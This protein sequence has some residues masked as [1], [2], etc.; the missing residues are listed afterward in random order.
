MLS[1]VQPDFLSLPP[2]TSFHPDNWPEEVGRHTSSFLLGLFEGEN[3]SSSINAEILSTVSC[4]SVGGITFSMRN[5]KPSRSLKN[6][7]HLDT[8]SF[9]GCFLYI[10]PL[11]P[12]RNFAWQSWE[13]EPGGA[14]KGHCI[15]A[16]ISLSLLWIWAG[17]SGL[18]A[19]ICVLRWTATADE[20]ALVGRRA[21]LGE[22]LE[23]ALTLHL[24]P[25]TWE[26]AWD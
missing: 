17:T 1:L 6:G 3:L 24:E 14:G 5:F 8:Q 18:G 13:T 23:N 12:T 2:S 9:R 11:W 19:Q 15:Y 4:G 10:A 22:R 7:W 21:Y 26:H 16:V 25:N 20:P